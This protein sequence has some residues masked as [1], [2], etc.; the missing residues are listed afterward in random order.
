LTINTNGTSRVFGVPGGVTAT[1]E[2][3]T[4]A[5]GSADQG[6]GIDNAGT[7]TVKQDAFLANHALG[8]SSS[9]ESLPH[10]FWRN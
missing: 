4:I 5:D 8:D 10:G 7:L 1:I 2:E 9:T 6:A 3:L